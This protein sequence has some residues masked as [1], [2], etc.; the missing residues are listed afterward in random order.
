MVRFIFHKDLSGLKVEKWVMRGGGQGG[1]WESQIE[2][3][4]RVQER[5]N[6]WQTGANEGKWAQSAVLAPILSTSKRGPIMFQVARDIFRKF[7]FQSF[8][9]IGC[10]HNSVLA[11][12]I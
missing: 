9:Q 8:L 12:K 3:Y 10:P 1:M 2:G 5:K 7:A 11:N 4:F 6:G